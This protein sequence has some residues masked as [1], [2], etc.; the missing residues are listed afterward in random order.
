MKRCLSGQ[1]GFTGGKRRLPRKTTKEMTVLGG[2]AGCINGYVTFHNSTHNLLKAVNERVFH[3]WDGSKLVA[4]QQPTPGVIGAQTDVL[5]DELGKIMER[6]A[7]DSYSFEQVVNHYTGR[8]R[9]IYQQALKD[10][11]ERGFRPK[12]AHIKSFVK[13]EKYEAVVKDFR[14]VVCRL[15]SPRSPVYNLLLGRFLLP[16]EKLVFQSI[17]ELVE[18]QTGGTGEHCVMK[19]LNAEQVANEF[20]KTCNRIGDW[21]AIGMDASRFDAHVHT[22]WLVREHKLYG[23]GLKFGVDRRRCQNLLKHQ[24]VNHCRA[25][26]SDAVIRYKVMGTRMSGDMNTSCGNTL[27]MCIAVLAFANHVGLKSW[28]F[29]NNGDDTVLL[30]SRSELYKVTDDIVEKYF[31]KLGFTME[32]E[33]RVSIFENIEFCQTNPCYNG[34]CYVMC[35]KLNNINK[36]AIVLKYPRQQHLMCAVAAATGKCGQAIH[37][38][39][40][41]LHSFYSAMVRLEKYANVKALKREYHSIMKEGWGIGASARGLESY[42]SDISERARASFMLMSG[43]TPS[44]QRSMEAYYDS[45]DWNDFHVRDDEI[46]H[47]VLWTP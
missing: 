8:K 14:K 43:I 38:G 18:R 15:I 1:I 22:D 35:R 34:N 44:V 26:T 31:A 11:N 27:I 9:K 41:V 32:L 46:A 40:P 39:V 5:F 36:D 6:A 45:I 28:G 10:L 3:M 37:K 13:F 2:L 23:R 16:L 47:K 20:E 4:P 12:D 25:F 33:K 21:V 29:K 7:L 42:S 19:G 17:D 24:L 30:L